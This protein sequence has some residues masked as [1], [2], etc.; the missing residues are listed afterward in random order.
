MLSAP[1]FSPDRPQCSCCVG[2]GEGV[3]TKART[4][5]DLLTSKSRGRHKTTHGPPKIIMDKALNTSSNASDTKR[6]SPSELFV[7]FARFNFRSLLTFPEGG[8]VLRQR[9]TLGQR[10]EL[11]S[12]HTAADSRRSPVH[13]TERWCKKQSNSTPLL[14]SALRW[15][16]WTAKTREHFFSLGSFTSIRFI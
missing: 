2:Q 9:S 12:R 7:E 4:T 5:L 6:A 8:C 1:M 16:A 10:T 14:Y 15:E 13:A 3:A 11:G